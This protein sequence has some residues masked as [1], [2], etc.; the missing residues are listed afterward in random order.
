MFLHITNFTTEP[1][2]ISTYIRI[3]SKLTNFITN[4]QTVSSTQML[5]LVMQ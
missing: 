2:T 1:C 5:C 4:T 3:M